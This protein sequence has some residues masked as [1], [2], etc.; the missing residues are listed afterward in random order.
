MQHFPVHS[1][2]VFLGVAIVYQRAGVWYLMYKRDE[3]PGIVY[4]LFEIVE[5]L[6]KGDDDFL[7]LLAQIGYVIKDIEDYTGCPL[8]TVPMPSVPKHDQVVSVEKRNPY[9]TML[10]LKSGVMIASFMLR[11]LKEGRLEFDSVPAGNR[12][13]FTIDCTTHTAK[14]TGNCTVLYSALSG[15][16]VE[17]TNVQ[18]TF[19]HIHEASFSH[20]CIHNGCVFGAGEDLRVCQ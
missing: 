2:G 15:S 5:G 4:S 14:L 10:E 12:Q 9:L 1:Q 18:A 3:R 17:L 8:S 19:C 13:I 11:Y 6:K 7:M 16:K 20:Q